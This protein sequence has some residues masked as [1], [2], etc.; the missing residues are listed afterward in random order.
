MH[1]AILIGIGT[2]LNDNPQ[3]NSTSFTS[4]IYNTRTTSNHST[5]SPTQVHTLPSPPPHNP[6]FPA[7]PFPIMQASLQLSK[8]AGQTSMGT[9]RRYHY[10]RLYLACSLQDSPGRRGASDS[11]QTRSGFW[12]WDR[13]YLCQ[14]SHDVEPSTP[15]LHPRRALHPSPTGHPD[16]DG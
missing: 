2:A 1:D 15:T 13:S 5:P 3:L 11:D 8:R 12:E 6:R 16:S 14:F 7:T 4:C 9:D 10:K